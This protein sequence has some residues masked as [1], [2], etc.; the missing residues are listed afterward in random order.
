MAGTT[1]MIIFFDELDGSFYSLNE[2][3]KKFVEIQVSLA[4]AFK[5]FQERFNNLNNY[6]CDTQEEDDD[7]HIGHAWLPTRKRRKEKYYVPYGFIPVFQR[8]LPY[9]RGA[10]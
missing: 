5:A 2:A 3:L 6:L 4:D 10:Y 1:P 9:Q 7:G 8:N